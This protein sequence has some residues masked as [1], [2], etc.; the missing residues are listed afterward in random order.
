MSDV[1]H[2]KENRETLLNR[3][4]F[5]FPKD[6]YN[7]LIEKRKETQPIACTAC[8]YCLRVCPQDISIP[9]EFALYNNYCNQGK[10]DFTAAGRFRYYYKPNVKGGGTQACIKCGKCEAVCPQKLPIRE[11]ISKIN[12]VL[13]EKRLKHYSSEKNVQILISLMKQHGVKRIVISPGTTNIC[14][15]YSVQQDED[16]ILY[17]APDERS[18]A[19]IACGIAEESGE[20]VAISCT[21]A[22]ASR[23]YLPG[24]TEAFYRKLPILAITSSQRVERVD[25]LSPQFIDRSQIQKDVAVFSTNIKRVYTDEDSNYVE[26]SINKALI[27]LKNNG[28]G[29]VHLNLE[30]DYSKDFSV[31]ELPKHRKIQYIEF[32]SELPDINSYEK[33]GVFVGAHRVWSKEF[34]KIVDEFCN[35]Y[36]AVVI[37]DQG[38]NYKGEC[39]ILAPLVLNLTNTL[40]EYTDFDLIIHIGQVSGGYIYFNT[41]E[42]WRVC[43]SGEIQDTF[44]TLTNVFRMREKSFF[45]S[46]VKN[47][48]KKKLIKDEL[49]Y[50]NYQNKYRELLKKIPELPFSNIW[51]AKTLAPQ[52]PKNSLLHLGILNSLRSWNFFPIDKSI[53]V[54]SNTGG[55]GIDGALSTLIGASLVNEN[56]LYFGIVGDLA[57][58]YDINS[59]AN[60]YVGKNLRILLVNNGGGTEFKHYSHDAAQFGDLADDF[61]AANG[62]YGNKSERLVADYAKNLGFNYMSAKNK[63]E[64]IELAK[65]FTDTSYKEK[66]I[67]FEVFTNQKD[68]SD[69][70]RNMRE[71]NGKKPFEIQEN[72]EFP[73]SKRFLDKE[74]NF[75]VWGTGDCF[76]SNIS[77]VQ[78]KCKVLY[79]LDNN[80]IKW[81]KSVF[82]DIKC[83]KPDKDSF[84]DIS[85]K[86]VFVI[87]MIE[88]VDVV[89]Q[90]TNQLLDMEITAFDTVSN[91]LK[92]P[93]IKDYNDN[94]KD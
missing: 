4:K 21:G 27:L 80:E 74:W 45:E 58:F 10:Y 59:L 48:T 37:A 64:F 8:E 86:D 49:L 92:Y 54:V 71:L 57:F 87:I 46:Y 69:A 15:S 38:S 6:F 94:T 53:S 76:R 25:R 83:V 41:R 35:I 36:N 82:D 62:H 1:R 2:I 22:T 7:S 60:R 18:A 84:K 50:S 11:Y 67:I 61:I 40:E 70:L 39:G 63:D 81:G 55:F 66:S 90:I 20:P 26:T 44:G 78:S 30:T 34:E 29:P 16:F 72:D 77:K 93:D 14:F 68:E 65:R 5:V 23:N 73:V 47:A 9:E 3:E 89:A 85:L 33:I 88:N 79:A 17:S 28:G 91:F 75:V 31:K 51:I 13:G 24:L 32:D 19:Y 52:I 56:K 42:V 12:K 43:E